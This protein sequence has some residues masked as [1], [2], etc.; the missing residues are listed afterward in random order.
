MLVILSDLKKI[1]CLQSLHLKIK[2]ISQF[3]NVFFGG[4]DIALIQASE[5]LSVRE[6][7]MNVSPKH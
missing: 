1:N 7:H 5:L 4:P 3:I 2:K 6:K